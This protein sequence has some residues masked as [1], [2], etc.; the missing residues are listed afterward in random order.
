MDGFAEFKLVRGGTVRAFPGA[1]LSMRSGGEKVIL[2][3]GKVWCDVEGGKGV[4]LVRT[5]QSEA[6]VVGT[7][8]VV[9]H[10]ENGASEVRVMEGT[11]NVTATK[12]RG[13]V[14]VKSGHKTRVVEGAPPSK[15]T[16]YSTKQD[17]LDWDPFLKRLWKDIKDATKD[18]KK[19]FKKLLAPQPVKKNE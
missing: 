13:R 5:P 2:D 6:K 16:H 11:V 7:S 17:R 10:T 18:L 14:Q 12:G 15:P 8:F 19:D 1:R 9:E 4:F 3:V